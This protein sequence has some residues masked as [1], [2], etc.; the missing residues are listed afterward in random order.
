MDADG[1][2]RILAPDHP[3][4]TKAGYVRE[5][6]LVMEQTLGRHLLPTEQV[7]H[8]NGRRDDNRPDNLELW[9]TKQPYGIRADDYHCAGCRC[10]ESGSR[11]EP[12]V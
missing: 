9:K 2:V 11:D 12:G 8:K 5:H 6:R 1:Y 7:H 3:H 10:G 4:A